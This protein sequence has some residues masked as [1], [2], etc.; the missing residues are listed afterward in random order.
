MK[1]FTDLI[2]FI[3]AFFCI[4]ITSLKIK[5]NPSNELKLR[6]DCSKYIIK[7]TTK[8]I[9]IIGK[10]DPN[11]QIL[12]GNHTTNLDIPLMESIIDEKIIWVAKKELG[13]IP[14]FKYLL[15]ETDMILIDR[16]N[17]KSILQMIK[18]IKKRVNKNLKVVIFPEGTRNKKNPKTMLKWKKGPK[19]VIEKLNLKV[20]PFVI[21]NLANTLQKTKINQKNIKIIFLPLIDTSDK[22]WY[23]KTYQKMNEILQRE[24]NEI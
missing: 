4:L 10:L 12:I 21:V 3:N 7:L 16:E 2:K 18:E 19:A 9:E 17:K 24:K 8:K 14:I 5:L 1:I 6:K 13:E 11:A 23:E 22:N 20:Q 15:T